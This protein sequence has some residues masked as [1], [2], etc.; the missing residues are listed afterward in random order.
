MSLPCLSSS[1]GAATCS[2][3]WRSRA[4]LIT[5]ISPCFVAAALCWLI[6]P[7]SPCFTSLAAVLSLRRHGGAV[8]LRL[9]CACAASTTS[10][11]LWPAPPACR[12]DGGRGEADVA[13]GLE[14]ARRSEVGDEGRRVGPFAREASVGE[15]SVGAAP[16]E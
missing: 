4:S 2:T 14:R 10:A 12:P 15:V 5:A 3:E 1:R 7:H 11:R 8:V 16:S 6:S 9:S 13:A